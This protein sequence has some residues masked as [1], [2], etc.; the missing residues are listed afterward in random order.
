[1]NK[2]DTLYQ[3]WGYAVKKLASKFSL[4]MEIRTKHSR[5]Q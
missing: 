2:N 3:Y 5:D 1:M 4:V